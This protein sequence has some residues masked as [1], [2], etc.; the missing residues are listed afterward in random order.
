MLYGGFQL[1]KDTKAPDLALSTTSQIISPNLD[2]L[3][4][5]TDSQSPVKRITVRALRNGRVLP[6]TDARFEGQEKSQTISFSIKDTGLRDGDFDLE[7]TVA[8][9]SFAW[10]GRGNEKTYKFPMQIDATPP[11]I[12]IKTS[13]P[14]V[15][16]GGAACVLYSVSKEVTRTG[17]NVGGLFFPA[18]R[19]NNGDFLCFFPFPYYM[20]P[21]DF[22]PSIE[23][24]DI[25]GNKQVNPVDV[26]TINR[27]FKHDAI[28]ISENFVKS[29]AAEFEAMVPGD[30]SDIDRFL[31]VNGLVR[32][33]SAEKLFEISAKTAPNIL[34]EGL[35]MRMPRS[36]N[37]AGFADHR[38]YMWEGE[39]VDEQTHL[40]LDLASVARDNVPAANN[41]III[42]TGYLGIYGN[43]V[44]IDH[45][46]GLHSL[47]SHLSEIN[48]E[49]GNEVK[50]GD[51]IGRTGAT[52]MAGGDHLHFG[53]LVGGLEVTP[54]EWLDPQWIRHNVTD[55]LSAAGLEF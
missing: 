18:Q 33:A 4:T 53:I 26:Y 32:K 48:T 43:L 52:G 6:V 49:I 42:Y 29:K 51:I 14:N 54:I 16:R 36:A 25:A 38:T 40:G 5:A 22:R 1:F 9:D 20:E 44:I 8:D 27:Q 47:Y 19:Q 28:N 46:A 30:M 13:Q 7:I 55:R 37:R 17:V 31:K 15:R 21:N 35:F 3:A 39:K 11:R 45:G 10:F 24:E 12:S 50:K 2:I 23:A 41:G 34:W